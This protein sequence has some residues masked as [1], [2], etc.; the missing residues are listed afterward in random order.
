MRKV[1][2]HEYGNKIFH[3]NNA[4]NLPWIK[5][6]ACFALYFIT[7][8]SS[9]CFADSVILNEE[10]GHQ[11]K[12]F[13][14]VKTWTDAKT[15][16]ESQG[17]HLATITSDSENN[18]LINNLSTLSDNIWIGASDAE[19]EGTWQWLTGES[20]SYTNWYPGE[21]N[22]YQGNNEDCLQA[23]FTKSGQWNDLPCARELYYICEWENGAD[24]LLLSVNLNTSGIDYDGKKMVVNFKENTE[25]D[26]QLSYDVYVGTERIDSG[27]YS[28]GT[29]ISRFEFPLTD[30]YLNKEISVFFATFIDG[31]NKLAGV[32]AAYD[33]IQALAPESIVS[34]ATLNDTKIDS[35][36]IRNNMYNY[37]ENQEYLGNINNYL[38]RLRLQ[39]GTATTHRIIDFDRIINKNINS[40][41]QQTEYATKIHSYTK[42]RIP[43]LLIH[44]WQGDN[45]GLKD[46]QQ[47]A[48][49]LWENSELNYWQHFLDFY[50]SSSKL[51]DKF[52]IYLYHYPTYKHICF[53][54]LVL[55][56][57]LINTSKA[58]EDLS[59]GLSSSK[60][61]FLAHSMGG[62]LARDLIEEQGFNNYRKLITL[63][64]PHHGS[65]ASDDEGLSRLVK[66]L[67][68]QGAADLNWDNVDKFDTD[69]DID[70]N[71]TSRRWT[72]INTK[73]FDAEYWER[74]LNLVGASEIDKHH[75]KNP[76]LR[77]LNVKFSKNYLK[78]SNKYI[79][80]VAGMHNIHNNI[81]DS[82]GNGVFDVS[83]ASIS[84]MGYLSGGAEPTGSAYFCSFDDDYLFKYFFMPSYT[85]DFTNVGLLSHVNPSIKILSNSSNE[86]Q[87]IIS[88]GSEHPYKLPYRL[89][90]DYD[91]EKIAN[92]CYKGDK[93]VWDKY[94]SASFVLDSETTS[95]TAFNSSTYFKSY[96]GTMYTC[97]HRLSL[98]D[99]ANINPLRY[100][101][102]FNLLQ[103]DLLDSIGSDIQPSVQLLLAN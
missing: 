21:P 45:T 51:Y 14:T 1:L 48:L 41:W 13:T 54:A 96:A 33:Q 20:W 18:F 100:E 73:D 92:G 102:V 86:T 60:L 55:K 32:N 89:F 62:L 61:I 71:N 7:T 90:V 80:Y 87:Y 6:C 26:K 64:T 95:D 103:K 93:G 43:I 65:P 94:V 35:N 70:E 9:P 101:P 28:G 3:T 81:P 22:S 57:L 25:F 15:D 40:Q 85:F 77:W 49:L 74:L 36:N 66:D 84:E 5:N 17:G 52:H 34:S 53:N 12:I 59:Y 42:H 91:H 27:S 79:L 16:C 76:W 75:T 39:V 88:T 44:G 8:L 56:N 4:L 11:Y 58:N 99:T 72:Y 38:D 98:G 78:Y 19:N 82:I 46:R 50:L 24:P 37:F 83:N 97:L 10:N 67:G 31:D 30:A 23:Y 63:D 29:Q 47:S 69:Q 2:R 68:T